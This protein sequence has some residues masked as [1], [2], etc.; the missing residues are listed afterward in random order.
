MTAVHPARHRRAATFLTALTALTLGTSL[1]LAQ[2]QAQPQPQVPAPKA[3]PAAGA[4]CTFYAGFFV[5]ISIGFSVLLRAAFRKSVLD[6]NA[7]PA[8]VARLRKS[9]RLGPPLYLAAT[10]AAPFSAW[11]AMGICSAL[12]IVWAATTREC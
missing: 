1:A 10:L 6:P 2:A 4:A 8:T 5:L 7:S 3:T 12:W 11:L 9:Y